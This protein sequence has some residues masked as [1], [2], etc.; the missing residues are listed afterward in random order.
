MFCWN[1]VKNKSLYTL[2]LNMLFAKNG[3]ENDNQNIEHFNRCLYQA[4]KNLVIS[5]R[6]TS[7]RLPAIF[8]RA[9]TA[10]SHTLWWG[11]ER[12]LTKLGTA[13]A[14][15]THL[16]WLLVPEAMFVRAQAASNC[17]SGLKPI[18]T[19]QIQDKNLTSNTVI[20]Y[21]IKL[22]PSPLATVQGRFFILAVLFLISTILG[23]SSSFKNMYLSLW[24]RNSTILGI[25]P[26]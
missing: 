2:V 3:L 6:C 17:S 14:F 7:N 21:D 19:N 5:V 22:S 4:T 9:H 10:C 11:E 20:D 16:V 24:P 25:T 8:P 18:Q 26:A 13:P 15:T 1:K 12:S 23:Y